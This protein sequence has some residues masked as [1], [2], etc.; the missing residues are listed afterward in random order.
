MKPKTK[1]T[2]EELQ[3][4]RLEL[5][6]KKENLR[7]YIEKL[8]TKWQMWNQLDSEYLGFIKK[9]ETKQIVCVSSPASIARRRG[10]M[11]AFQKRMVK[12]HGVTL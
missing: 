5:I 10:K 12:K 6:N 1:I 4:L 2:V 7:L 9:I 8:E 11:S 3:T